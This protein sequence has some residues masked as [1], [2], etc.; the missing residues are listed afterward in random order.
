VQADSLIKKHQE[1]R[2]KELEEG[3]AGA[4]EAEEYRRGGE[5]GRCGEAERRVEEAKEELRAT[6]E[7]AQ[8]EREAWAKQKKVLVAEVQ[9][10]RALQS[11]DA[12]GRS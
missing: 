6:V 5:C 4:K 1:Q 11:G 12:G 9:R 8:R 7:G 2:I 3:R 10:L